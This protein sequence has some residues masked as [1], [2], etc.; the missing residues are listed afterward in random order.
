MARRAN[1]AQSLED[2]RANPMTMKQ[3]ATEVQV[4][5]APVSAGGQ[6][7]EAGTEPRKL[8]GVIPARAV[9]GRRELFGALEQVFPVRFQGCE[10]SN[11]DALDGVL[12]I[13]DGR[14][15]GSG[16]SEGMSE[17][18]AQGCPTLVTYSENGGLAPSG[19][20]IELAQDEQIARLLRE[21]R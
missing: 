21:R 15:N 17:A 2:A 12:A 14:N 6:A 10:G 4:H 7:G 1:A 8:V 19:M 13:S 9:A 16:P 20:A 5:P 11:V 3:A 18:I